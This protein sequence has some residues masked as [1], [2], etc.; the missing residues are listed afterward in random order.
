MDRSL[1]REAEKKQTSPAGGECVEKK[2]RG[3]GG[4]SPEHRPATDVLL[5]LRQ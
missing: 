3:V 2:E 1:T 5:V 4:D